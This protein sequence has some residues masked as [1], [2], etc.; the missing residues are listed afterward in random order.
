MF[1]LDASWLSIGTELYLVLGNVMKSN[2]AVSQY[3]YLVTIMGNYMFRC[4]LRI[5]RS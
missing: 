5:V 2:T 3:G 4:V 1:S